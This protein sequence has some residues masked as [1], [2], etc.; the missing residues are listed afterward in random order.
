MYG[1]LVSS[2]CQLKSNLFSS[3]PAGMIQFVLFDFN[4]ATGK[5]TY[6]ISTASFDIYLGPPVLL[7]VL[8]N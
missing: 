8:G 3:K 7:Q 1:G 5:S 4:F 2:G 6:F